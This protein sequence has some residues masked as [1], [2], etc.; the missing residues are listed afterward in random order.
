MNRR[1]SSRA[2][3]QRKPG[4]NAGANDLAAVCAAVIGEMRAGRLLEAQLRCRRALEANPEEPELLH[5]MALIYLNAA[6]FDHVVEWVSRAIRTDPKPSYLTT[7]GTALQRS[8]RLEDASKAFDKAI[9]FKPDDA[10]LWTKLGVVLEELKRP[11]EAVLCFQHALKLDPLHLEAACGSAVLL[12]QLGR[13]EEALTQC[14]LCERLRPRHALTSTLRS[15]VLRGL[16]KHEEYLAEA[17]RAHTLDPTNAEMCRNVGDALLLLGRFEEALEWFDRSLELN[18]PL[19]PALENKATVLRRMHRFDELFAI[20][21]HIRSIDPDNAKVE[22]SLANDH[23]MLGNFEAGWRGRE[24]RWRIPGFPVFFPDS[25]VPV[26]LGEESIAGKTILIYSDEGLGDAILFARYLPMLAARGA[27]VVLVVQEALH[28]LLSSLP[29]LS[30]CLAMSAA[31]LPPVDF[32]CPIMSLPFAFRTKLEAVPPPIRLPP[33]PGRVSVWEE[34]LGPRDRLRVG[35]TW[36]G[37][38]THPNDQNRSIPLQLLTRILDVNA[39]FVSLQKDPRSDDRA[40]L[41]ERTEIVDLTAHLTDFSET[42]ALVSCL[43]LVI[44]VDTSTAHLAATM[45]CPTWIMLPHTPDYRWLLNRDD[46]PWYPAVRLFR[47]TETR[48]YASVIERIRTELSS[49]AARKR[50]GEQN[51]VSAGSWIPGAPPRGVPG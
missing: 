49:A 14:D 46:S 30:H 37:S 26:W 20:Y 15:L 51:P 38:L 4:L 10:A 31:A 18:P 40:V 24:A 23:L 28:S 35:L 11:S 3:K 27:R 34:R 45:G 44:T 29:G 50:V 12:H 16:K 7:L 1:S 17:R 42:A 43:D 5:L 47:Q 8:G 39:T 13:L 6:E 22:F 25:P 48:E 41:L 32:R 19:A 33:Q 9:Q 36:S 21:D 2:A